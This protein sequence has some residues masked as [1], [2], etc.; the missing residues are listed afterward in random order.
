MVMLDSKPGY[1]MGHDVHYQVSGVLS[2]KY[3]PLNL[4]CF[5]R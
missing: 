5:K 1:Y 2:L 4:E 3:L